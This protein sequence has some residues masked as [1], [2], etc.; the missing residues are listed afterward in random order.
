MMVSGSVSL[1][2]LARSKPAV[3]SYHANWFNYLFGKLVVHIKYM[4]LPNLLRDRVIMPE[5][6]FVS[7]RERQVNNLHEVLNRWLTSPREMQAAAREMESLRSEI[8]QTGGV[9]K[10]A[11][12]ISPAA[13]AWGL[14]ASCRV[15]RNLL[16]Q[17]W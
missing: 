6:L 11:D 1:E 10:A 2:V 12:T 3:V 8:V 5:F 4:S 15:V 17:D 7:N 14:A 9:A 13:G 16:P